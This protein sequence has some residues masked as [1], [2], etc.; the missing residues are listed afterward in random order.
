MYCTNCGGEI[1]QDG[2]YCAFCGQA[3]VNANFLSIGEEI[4]GN[5][6]VISESP[7]VQA[8]LNE[9]NNN[10]N[11]NN[12]TELEN[13]LVNKPIGT[14]L[15]II[16]FFMNCLV[17]VSSMLA[18]AFYRNILELGGFP[19]DGGHI[20]ISLIFATGYIIA[21]FIFALY[22]DKS[23]LLSI[24]CILILAISVYTTNQSFDMYITATIPYN[25]YSYEYAANAFLK[26]TKN[27]LN[28]VVAM[29]IV[30]ATL[31]IFKLVKYT[32]TKLSKKSLVVVISVVGIVLLL[33]GIY[34]V[35][36]LMPSNNPEKVVNRFYS[37]A[38]SGNYES[39]KKFMGQNSQLNE[40]DFQSFSML[41]K[42][43]NTGTGKIVQQKLIGTDLTLAQDEIGFIH[44]FQHIK[45]RKVYLGIVGFPSDY[46]NPSF[47]VELPV[48][49]LYDDEEIQNSIN[50]YK[51]L[52]SPKDV[53]AFEGVELFNKL[54]NDPYNET[55]IMQIYNS[56]FKDLTE[57]E[58][59]DLHR[60][61]STNLVK[62]ML[63][64]GLDKE[65]AYK[66]AL[67]FAQ[68]ISENTDT[69]KL[70]QRMWEACIFF[71]M[72]KISSALALYNQNI[73]Q[74]GDNN[75]VEIKKSII[76]NPTNYNIFQSDYY[77]L[78]YEDVYTYHYKL[79]ELTNNKNLIMTIAQQNN[80]FSSL[81]DDNVKKEYLISKYAL[82]YK[83]LEQST[84][85]S[86]MIDIDNDH[87]EEFIIYGNPGENND[88]LLVAY[89][90]KNGENI[91]SINLGPSILG[92]DIRIEAM[93]IPK[94][95]GC[96]GIFIHSGRG[97]D[98]TLYKYKNNNYIELG[99]LMTEVGTFWVGDHDNDGY[100]E[101]FS[102]EMDWENSA[103]M[104]DRQM[105]DYIYK[106]ENGHFEKYQ[107]FGTVYEDG[108]P[109]GLD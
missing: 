67:F 103:S 68:F 73:Q 12:T 50:T 20:F 84:I 46:Y 71:K 42:S 14:K 75:S 3:I 38:K 97:E 33:I 95:N 99:N 81:K 56:N 69:G 21:L 96:I 89:S 98:F 16:S 52:D 48:N 4:I 80:M 28:V 18:F 61:I 51:S 34:S 85:K 92:L 36:S 82:D 100:N 74:Y 45:N 49:Y 37:I 8:S 30:N 105:L 104:A 19:L 91:A 59:K 25:G 90:M 65:D 54:Q 55:V 2:R 43:S 35:Y 83:I 40:R 41:I 63:R 78:E 58:N 66:K 39:Y 76:E 62:L 64:K 47:T 102:E 11:E 77:S 9:L 32:K 86:F 101:I 44:G 87:N 70:K 15:K 53:G 1:T 106:W 17:A 23:F 7:S 29:N 94:Y 22:T 93:R 13:I 60:I 6:E 27:V 57:E 26:V 79:A 24:I 108:E 10:S 72:Q 31:L 109:I 88:I 5:V 107:I